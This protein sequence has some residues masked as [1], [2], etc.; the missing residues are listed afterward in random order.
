MPASKPQLLARQT[1]GPDGLQSG[2]L[3]CAQR[4]DDRAHGIDP[5]L[6]IELADFRGGLVQTYPAVAVATMAWC[7][8]TR[9]ALVAVVPMS[10]PRYMSRGSFSD[11]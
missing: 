10:R 1:D 5:R 2:G 6:R 9:T 7:S 3:F 8:S 11:G 4:G